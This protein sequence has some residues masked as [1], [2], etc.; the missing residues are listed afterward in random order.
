[1]LL[2]I[3]QTPEYETIDVVVE[4]YKKQASYRKGRRPVSFEKIS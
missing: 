3:S 4:I 1:M 2:P